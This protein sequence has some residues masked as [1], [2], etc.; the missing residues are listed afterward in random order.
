MSANVRCAR[1]SLQMRTHLHTALVCFGMM[2]IEI[3]YL[4]RLATYAGSTAVPSFKVRSDSR[5]PSQFVHKISACNYAELMVLT[6]L[7]MKGR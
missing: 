5:C 3:V 7:T 6:E 4:V 2:V 1:H